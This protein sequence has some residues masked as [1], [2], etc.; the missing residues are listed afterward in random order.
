MA[1]IL[2]LLS[3]EAGCLSESRGP[4]LSQECGEQAS[5][6]AAD[7]T[8]LVGF[9]FSPSAGTSCHALDLLVCAGSVFGERGASGHPAPAPAG[10]ATDEAGTVCM[11]TTTP[12]E[13]ATAGFTR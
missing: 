7:R 1:G 5:R 10:K 13:G 4:G 9:L 6:G 12:A 11:A 3:V 8:V 2:M